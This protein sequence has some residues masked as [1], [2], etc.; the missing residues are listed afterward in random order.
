MP[1]LND[2]AADSSTG[3]RG[4]GESGAAVRVRSVVASALETAMRRPRVSDGFEPTPN[5][6]KRYGNRTHSTKPRITGRRLQN[7]REAWF[8][9]HPLCARCR[10]KGKVRVAEQLDHIVAL[11]NGGL[12]FD[13]DDGLNRQGLCEECHKAKTA[14]D[15][16]FT[17]TP[18]AR[19]GMDGWPLDQSENEMISESKKKYEKGEGGSK[20]RV[21][22]DRK[23]L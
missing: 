16:G 15:Q 7:I 14:E 22:P 6:S 4:A 9:L 17:H 10:A 21:L 12:D 8:G 19:I 5:I 11:M 2:R 18:K 23:P 3:I 13:Q 1:G 20:V